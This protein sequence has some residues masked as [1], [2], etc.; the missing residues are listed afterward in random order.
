MAQGRAAQLDRAVRAYRHFA[1]APRGFLEWCGGGAGFG[2]AGGAMRL[3]ATP[4]VPR[5]L[6]VYDVAGIPHHSIHWQGS[7]GGDL[8]SISDPVGMD[9]AS[10]RE[11]FA[12]AKIKARPENFLAAC[13]TGWIT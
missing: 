9:S 2:C 3:A 10:G 1:L 5:V 12:P 4:V 7:F 8:F 11:R 6:S 13:Q